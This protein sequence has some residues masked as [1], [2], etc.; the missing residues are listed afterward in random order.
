MSS[1]VQTTYSE[2]FQHLTGY[3]PFEYQIKVARFL[4]EGRNI[5][6]RAPTGAGKTLAV[7]VP[8]LFSEWKERP[9][10]LIYALPLR[11]LAQGVYREAREAAVR[12]GL[13]AVSKMDSQRREMMPPYVTLQTGE[14]PDDRFFDR[15]R[16]IV[17]TYDQLL[18][19]ILTGPYG[20]SDRLHNVNAAIPVG[21]LI[22][23]DEFHLM[24]PNRAFLTA[25]ACLHLFRN[26]CQS[27]WMTATATRSLEEVLFDGLNTVTVPETEAEMDELLNSLPS[28]TT[29]TRR[30]TVEAEPVSAEF[31]L[32][33]HERRSI[34][35]LNTVRRA[36][37]MLEDLQQRIEE[38]GVAIRVMLLHS[39]FF[40]G[41]RRC[42]EEMLRSLF[43]KGAMESAILVA[44]QVIEAGIDIS[45]DHLHTELCP[46]NALVQR[47]G[48]CARFQGEQGKVH[49]YPLPSEERAWLPYGD[50]HKEDT[51]LTETRKLLQRINSEIFH[52]RPAIAWV[53]EVHGADDEQALREGWQS[54]LNTCLARIEQSALLR[55]PKRIADLIRGEDSD[56][57]R[58]IINED[59]RRPET[60]GQREGLNLSRWSLYRLF[61]DEVQNIGWFWDGTDE[62][63]WKPLENPSDFKNTYVVCL[64]PA[65]ASY[66][67]DM[68]LRL[69]VSGI[70][71]SPDRTEP[72]RPGYAPLRAE[73]WSDH[74][75]RVAEEAQK[76]LEREEWRNGLLEKGF[77]ERYGLSSDAISEAAR[78]SALLHDLGKLQENWQR[79]AE[80]AQ[81]SRDPSYQHKV[82]LA[83]TDFDPEK[84]EDRKREHSLG[85][86]RPSHAPASA[87]YARVFLVRL[88][89]SVP[90]DQRAYVASA[91]TA[92]ILTHHGGW[93]VTDL[94][95]QPPKLWPGWKAAVTQTLG[96]E[97]DQEML[98]ILRNYEVGKLLNAT[99]SAENLSEWWP[100]VSYL[101][102]TLRLSDQRSTA[103]GALHE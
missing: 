42:K 80:A 85:I 90:D 43:G 61:K 46:M 20:L 101:I 7:L 48:R 81:Q 12:V 91:C 38:R 45:C 27:V 2:F 41:D 64:R 56:S 88:L 58:V 69:G 94:E 39:R 67:T 62:E 51:T 87:Y 92:T 63:P 60:P 34:V 5:V 100:L 52:P 65:V 84:A 25:T 17:T 22:V 37:R 8:F 86:Q 24:E 30:I 103:E 98:N 10:R 54:R 11:T 29:V 78:A 18:S 40:K 26:L 89:P 95:L 72:N 79:W 77:K 57:L 102:R 74:A 68:G 76:R 36:Q 19:G 9:A 28:V 33:S 71:E 35:L 75:R 55:D 14:Q 44:T 15:G 23:F 13:P 73:P 93:W 53:Q 97:P 1:F 66:D 47:A 32:R 31:V 83:H 49:V 6:L 21:S 96:W 82:P 70:Q 50:L 99:T 59:V 16:I 3:S 4:F